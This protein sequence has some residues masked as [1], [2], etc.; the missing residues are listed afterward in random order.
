MYIWI[1]LTILFF[2]IGAWPIGIGVLIYGI[3]SITSKRRAKEKEEKENLAAENHK[4]RQE[5]EQ[6]QIIQRV[7]DK[8]E[9]K[10]T[11]EAEK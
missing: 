4:L 10:K 7:M 9:K 11:E 2:C 3:Y 8:T 6:M 5:L 1:P